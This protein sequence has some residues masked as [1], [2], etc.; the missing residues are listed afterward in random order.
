M[1]AVLGQVEQRDRF[2]CLTAR[3]RERADA[4][5]ER[6]HALLK[7]RLCRVHD[8]RVDVAELG[9]PEKGRGVRRVPEDVARRLVDRHRARPGGRV[10]YGSSMDL[11]GLETP[12]GHVRGLLL[13]WVR[14]N[15]SGD[16]AL[17]IGG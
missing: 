8:A 6:G 3:D 9:E 10:G 15:G 16:R 12:V 4:A 7:D 17:A 13:L 11:A 5:V 1:P 2:G 14:I